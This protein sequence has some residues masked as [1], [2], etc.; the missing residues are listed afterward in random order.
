MSAGSRSVAVQQLGNRS[1]RIAPHAGLRSWVEDRGLAVGAV[2][3]AAA[4]RVRREEVGVSPFVLSDRRLGLPRPSAGHRHPLLSGRQ[5]ARPHRGGTDQRDRGRP[6][7]DDAASSRGRP[8]DQLRLSAVE[9]SRLGRS[10]R[11]VLEAVSREVSSAAAKPGVR[12]AHSRQSVRAD[13]R[14]KAP[15]RGFRR[16]VRHSGS[17]LARHGASG[18][19]IGRP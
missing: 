15:R 18:I 2:H 19:A 11:A 13:L 8:Y 12:S 10:L 5:T 6:D 17:P 14:P 16:D 3:R 7:D 4:P 9:G 1:L